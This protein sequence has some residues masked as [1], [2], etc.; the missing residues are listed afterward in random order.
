MRHGNDV[1]HQRAAIE[2]GV[3]PTSFIT[4]ISPFPNIWILFKPLLSL[5]LMYVR[6]SKI[7]GLESAAGSA[8]C[9]Q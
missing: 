9:S 4:V 7:L 5:G 2:N 3:S 8:R 6:N 1:S